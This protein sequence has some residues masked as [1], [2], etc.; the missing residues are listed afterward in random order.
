MGRKLLIDPQEA[1]AL[2]K[3]YGSITK[4]RDALAAR[5][6]RVS[7]YAVWNALV[8]T[9]E[10][11]ALAAANSRNPRQSEARRKRLAQG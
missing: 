10:G 9:K 5:G 7:R 3:E 4:V 1:L 11:A 2:Y 8:R 6:R